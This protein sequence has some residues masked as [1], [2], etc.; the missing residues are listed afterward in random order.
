VGLLC[1]FNGL[2]VALLGKAGGSLVSVGGGGARVPGGRV[3][4]PP[5]D[6]EGG[7]PPGLGSVGGPLERSVRGK[8]GSN[9]SKL[10]VE[11]GL[12]GS[13]RREG[14]RRRNK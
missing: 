3:K 2:E 1:S 12:Q 13:L 8:E 4:L 11:P 14:R 7:R 6:R 9:T 10:C 5:E